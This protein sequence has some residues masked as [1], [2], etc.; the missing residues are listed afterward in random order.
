MSEVTGYG[1]PAISDWVEGPVVPNKITITYI[2]NSIFT[3]EFTVI[4][5]FYEIDPAEQILT[6]LKKMFEGHESRSEIYAFY[7]SM[8]NLMYIGKTSNLLEETYLH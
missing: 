3:P 4:N 7:D 5:E 6:Q 8:A 1:K 2:L